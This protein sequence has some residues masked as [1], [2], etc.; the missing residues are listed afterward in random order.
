MSTPSANADGVALTPRQHLAV[1]LSAAELVDASTVAQLVVDTSLHGDAAVLL[2]AIEQAGATADAAVYSEAVMQVF[3]RLDVLEAR[4]DGQR[5][6]SRAASANNEDWLLYCVLLRFDA[7]YYALYKC[8]LRR[9]VDYPNLQNYLCDLHQQSPAPESVDF[10][11]IKRHYYRKDAELNPKGVVPLGGVPYL[12]GPHDRAAKF[13]R[14]AML[15]RATED[16]HAPARPGEWIRKQSHHREWI[17]SDDNARFAAEPNRYH[18]YVA[19]NCPW[20]HRV[21]LVRSIKRLQSF[22]SLDTLYYRRDPDHG[23]QFRPELEGFDPDS[24]YGYRFITELYAQV[25]SQERSVPV[26]FDKKTETIVSNESA[27]IVRMLNSAFDK[28]AEPTVDLYPEPLRAEIDQLNSWIY[29]AINNGAYKAGFTSS[30]EAYERAYHRFFDAFEQ[31]DER[32]ATRRFL[33]GDAMT[34]ADVRLFPTAF[35]FDHVYYV[36]FKL[37]KKMLRDYRHLHRWLRDMY[38][39]SG[40][41]EGSNL[42]HARQGYFGRTGNSLV[43]LGPVFD[44]GPAPTK[45]SYERSTRS[46]F[47]VIQAPLVRSAVMVRSILTL[48]VRVPSWVP[49]RRSSFPHWRTTR[50]RKATP[51]RR[52]R[53]P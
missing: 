34:E 3:A 9:I 17:S 44:I 6:L 53:P 24:V 48:W 7:V 18:L 39:S 32:L 23:W 41:A 19:N 11:A 8:N 43:P 25:G 26:L 12:D 13:D 28:L 33:T 49:P 51:P 14:N 1:L 22:I 4:L 16:G 45:K 36:R 35:R 2:K 38:H 46:F 20:C 52:D 5:Y 29:S 50:A 10:E 42:E 31:L 27:D 40:V 21:S 47:Q 15:S 37:N 30:Q